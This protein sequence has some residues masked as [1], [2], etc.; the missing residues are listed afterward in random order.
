MSAVCHLLYGVVSCTH[1]IS[2]HIKGTDTMMDYLITFLNSSSLSFLALISVPCEKWEKT[3]SNQTHG[4][5]MDQI[6][7]VNWEEWRKNMAFIMSWFSLGIRLFTFNSR[8]HNRSLPRRA[9][10]WIAAWPGSLLNASQIWVFRGG[11][12]GVKGEST[13]SQKV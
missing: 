2:L 5:Q 13:K 7:I 11:R 3:P 10:W 1:S 12:R 9:K 6:S 4:H 8:R